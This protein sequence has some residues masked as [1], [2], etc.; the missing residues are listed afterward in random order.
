MNTEELARLA[1]EESK[2]RWTNPK[3]IEACTPE[4]IA[5]LCRV[6]KAAKA[7]LDWDARSMYGN[8]FDCYSEAECRQTKT[9]KRVQH[10]Y[11]GELLLPALRNLEE[12]P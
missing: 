3:Y 7:V 8:C 9:C 6:A 11:V 10:G 4:R 1:A 5:A 2:S 12:T